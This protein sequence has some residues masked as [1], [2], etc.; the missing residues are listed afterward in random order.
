MKDNPLKLKL[1]QFFGNRMPIADTIRLKQKSTYILPT[2]AGFLL[3]AII[4][5][6]MIA[7]TNY[8]NNLAFL[9]TFLIL[10]LGLV[11]ILFTFKN[12]QGLIFKI[13]LVESVFAGQKLQVNIHLSSQSKLNHFTIGTGVSASQV[14][15]CDVLTEQDNRIVIPIN[16]EHR[17]WFRLPRIMATSS[18]PFGLLRVW[19]WFQFASPVLV[20]PTPIEPPVKSDQVGYDE[21]EGATKISGNDDLYGLKTYQAGDPISRIDWKA[22]ARER[23]LFSK[24]FVAY[25]SQDLVFD[26]NDFPATD[27]EKRLSYLCYLVVE[28]SKCNYEYSLRLPEKYI[29]KDAGEQHKKQCL[30]ALALFDT[31]KRTDVEKKIDI[32]RKTDKEKNWISG[33]TE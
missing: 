10:S 4:L 29:Q 21:E 19:S 28:A 24:E 2:R 16:S 1:R 13:G 12:L 11:S 31:K 18:F 14:Y 22:L 6:M 9:L 17:G 32:D 26:W 5:L 23:G 3:V 20:Y 27:K 25:Q 8:Q 30:D 15:F 33:E 7:A